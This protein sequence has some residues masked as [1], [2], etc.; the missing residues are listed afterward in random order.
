MN[1]KVRLISIF[2]LLTLL[3]LAC[4]ALDYGVE[5]P[6]VDSPNEV[7]SPAASEE[8]NTTTPEN[9][10]TVEPTA[11]PNTQYWKY[12]ED[13]RFGVHFAIPCFWVANIPSGQQDPSG[14]GSFPIQNFDD[15]YIARLGAKRGGTVWEYGGAKMDVSYLQPSFWN[16]PANASLETVATAMFSD[17]TPDADTSITSLQPVNYN[18][19][20]GLKVNTNTEIW[21]PGQLY[22]FSLGPNLV[23]TV[24]LV[25]NAIGLPDSEAILSS[26]AL[27]PDIEVKLPTIRPADP[28]AGMGASCLGIAE[29]EIPP[30]QS[31]SETEVLTGKLDCN[32]V[33]PNEWLMY[34]ACNVQDSIISRNTQPLPGYMG[35]E[36]MVGYWQSE[37]RTLTPFEGM[38]EIVMRMPADTSQMSFTTDRSKLPPLFGMTPEQLVNPDINIVEVIYSEGWGEDKQ[39]AALLYLAENNL[40]EIYFYGIVFAQTHFDK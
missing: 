32:A 3:S 4:G 15:A 13:P 29:S 9:Q 30:L 17:S 26:I 5:Q 11:H 1:I 16:L 24:S 36:F 8:T 39:G 33:T 40:N 7:N 38:D 19:Q 35:D 28:P 18:G 27:T 12:I 23:L 20:E 22:I 21:G 37:G 31:E 34:V 6:T 14:M 25:Q 10:P 2:I